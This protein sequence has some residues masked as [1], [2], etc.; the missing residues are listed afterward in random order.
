MKTS[1]PRCA[2]IYGDVH[3]PPVDN[4][5][6]IGSCAS[7]AI[8]R[9]QFTNAVSRLIH[10]KNGAAVFCPRD[11]FGDVFTPKYSYNIAGPGTAW[12]YEF[13]ADHGALFQTEGIFKKAETGDPKVLGGSIPCDKEGNRYPE[14]SSMLVKPGQMEKALNYRIRHFDQIWVTKPPYSERLTA[15]P[16]GQEL[17]K[18]IKETVLRGDAVV[19]GGYP[20]RWVFTPLENCGT[21]GKAGEKVCVAAAGRGGGGHQVTIVGYDDDLTAVFA[22]VRLTGAFLVVNSYGPGWQNKGLCWMAYDSVNTV[23][24]HPE[25][26]D[27]SLY[28]GPMYLTPASGFAMFPTPLT[29]ENQT[30]T[31]TQKGTY[32]I[33]G[34]TYAAYTVYDAKNKKYLSY[35]PDKDDRSLTFTEEEGLRFA[36]VPYGDMTAFLTSDKQYEKELYKDSYWIYA[37]DKENDIESWRTLD[38][39]T[40]Y[41]A[42]GRT[43]GLAS[44]NAGRYPEAKSWLLDRKPAK[45]FSSR[46]AIAAGKDEKSERIWTLDQFCFID[47]QKD[48]EV[49]MPP[50][51]IKATVSADDRDCFE[52]YITRR[53]KDGVRTKKYLPAMFRYRASRPFYGKREKGGYMNFEG[54][55][56][57][58]ECLGELAFSLEPLLSLPAG[59]TFDDYEW[60]LCLKKGRTGRARIVD[61]SLC[62]ADKSVL[63][64]ERPNGSAVC[65]RIK[66]KKSKGSVTK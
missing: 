7:Q 31:F 34:K 51:Y 11:S 28:S 26:N 44:H 47:W 29:A 9:N 30:L 16:E 41:G 52:I 33:Y 60:G 43:C 10:Q 61:A 2:S 57:G 45:S 38:A 6:G 55:Y 50:Y 4:Q 35:N 20:G 23:S 64:F 37:V 39:G 66:T 62:R 24:E 12:V 49:G 65:F 19:T 8:T 21:L 17:L 18:R 25:L 58:G 5:G 1:L 63:S 53:L 54:I 27:A 36:L 40:S 14:S 46:L 22:G 42:S 59:R 32:E 3:F 13:I 56:K 48:V 15:C